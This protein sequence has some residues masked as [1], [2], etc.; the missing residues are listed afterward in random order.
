MDRAG[1][2]PTAELATSAQPTY[3]LSFVL[4]M[5]F[6]PMIFRMKT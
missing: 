1:F 4:R 2:E 3:F 5:G 6:E